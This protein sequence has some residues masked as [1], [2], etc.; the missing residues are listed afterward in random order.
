MSQRTDRKVLLGVVKRHL[1][2]T[3]CLWCAC[4]YSAIDV[5]AQYRFDSWTTENGL[6]QASVS[7]ILQTRDGFLWFATF[8]GLVRYDGLRFQ[9]FN[10]GNT[11]G[12]R[13]GRFTTLFEDREGNLWITTEGQGLTRY[14][15][16][17]FTTFSTDSGLTSNQVGQVSE[18]PSGNVLIPVGEGVVQWKNGGFTPYQPAPGEPFNGSLRRTASGA[19]WYQDGSILRKYERGRVTVELETG[20]HPRIFFEDRAGRLWIGTSEASLLMYQDG[21]LKVFSEKE[22]YPQFHLSAFFEDQQGVLWFG[23]T[24]QGLVQLKDGRFTR[25][26]TRDGLAGTGVRSIYQDREGT[27]WVGTESG[28][29]RMTERVITAYSSKDGLAADN[30][31]PIYEDRQGIIWIGSW[32]GLT[33]YADGVFTNVSQQFGLADAQITSLL[34][35]KAGV[36]WIG[37]WGSGVRFIKDGKLTVIRNNEMPGGHVRAITQDRAGNIWFG[38]MRGVVKY[39]DG[40]FTS[41]SSSD[42]LA[43]KEI[44]TIYEDRQGRIWI[45]A[46]NGLTKYQDGRFAAFTEKDGLT[47]NIV[48]AIH[49]DDSGTLWIGM[50]DTGLYRFKDGHFTHYTTREGL[51]DNGVFRIIEDRHDNFWI[52]CN[53]GIYRVRKD[54]LNA[55][56]EGRAKEIVSIP[57]NKRDGMLN[58]E[59]NGGG[60][61]AGIRARDGRIWFPT[62]GGVA[63][64]DPDRVPVNPQPPLVVIE[65]LIVDTLPVSA[66]ATVELRPG[67]ANIEI[68]YS[69]LSFINPELVKF[70]YKLQGLDT[71][72]VDAGTRRTAYY[73]HLPPG[74]YSFTV[75]A[76][77]RDGVWNEK[78]ATI[79]VVVY[80]P[81]WRTWWFISLVVC[82][83]ALIALVFYRTRIA[84]LKRARRTQEAFSNQLIESQERERKRIAAELHDSLGQ[85]LLVIKNRA[86]LGLKEPDNPAG[87]REQLEEISLSAADA[88]EEVREIAYYLRPSQLER[89]GLTSTLEEM[90]TKVATSSDINFSYHVASLDGAFSAAAESNFIRIV[91]ETINNIIKHSGAAEANIVIDRDA[92]AVHLTVTD[93]GKGFATDEALDNDARRRG[94]GLIGL[95]ERVRMLGGSHLIRSTPGAGTTIS[96]TIKTK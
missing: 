35:D 5:T 40:K 51:F 14:K 15:D 48:R 76:A 65:S 93:N 96:V 12:L 31:Y 22:G 83:V 63:I 9:V 32:L 86:Y 55:F 45:G 73:A 44:Q 50:Y 25:Y 8:G 46:D 62:Q 89:I 21:K 58:S 16:E 47:N 70:K 54:E 41:Y 80:P 29:S 36:L 2:S 10:P 88:L 17:V 87:A 19:V 69:G 11:K 60:Q 23:T 53:L 49:E 84:Q 43:G 75:M 74:R 81:F 94:F 72:W 90:L 28:L 20:F 91:Q 37:T 79:V 34:E 57:Y 39:S 59:C 61:P 64:I 95:A 71:D 24:G 3:L 78:G 82:S 27:I 56:A 4:V 1:L 52:S 33:R 30:V 68:H 18:D 6:P 66:R 85:S 67:Q 7:S 42:G 77:N 38:T 92:Q 13:T 26:T